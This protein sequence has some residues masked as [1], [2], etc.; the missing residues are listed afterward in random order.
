[1]ENINTYILEKL[2]INKNIEISDKVDPYDARN[3]KIGDIICVVYQ[4]SSRHV[5]FFKITGFKGKTIVQ[6]KEL[7]KKTV[8]GDWQN[9]SCVPTE[10][11]IDSEDTIAKINNKGRLKLKDYFCYLWNGEPEDFYTD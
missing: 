10:E 2:R 1:M 6:M 7:K 3:Y 11:I 4:Y 8:S 5:H 9:G